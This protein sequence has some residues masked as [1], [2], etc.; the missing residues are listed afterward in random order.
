VYSRCLF[1]AHDLGRNEAI[2]AFPVGRRLAYDAAKGRLWVVCPA[3][4]RWNLT[5]LEERWEATEQAER[6]FRTSR[7]RVS[8]DNVGLARVAGGADLVRVGRPL[9]PELAA[10]RYGDVF[11]RRRRRA[12]A[13]T[14]GVRAA[15]LAGT[16]AIAW[17][18]VSSGLGAVLLLSAG[19]ELIK[20]GAPPET[21]ASDPQG[22]FVVR[23]PVSGVLVSLSRHAVERAR[24]EHTD[25]RGLDL[26]FPFGDAWHRAHGAAAVRGTA[27]LLA[28]LNAA[29]APRALVAGAVS[30]LVAAGDAR[31]FL[32]RVG[33]APTRRRGYG[34]PRAR[35]AVRPTE[36]SH[37]LAALDP[38]DRLALEMALHDDQERAALDGE[39]R[40]L[41]EAWREAESLAAIADGLGLPTRVER[42]LGRLRTG[43]PP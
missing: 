25:A 24:L 17:W 36:W 11:G 8:T 14:A 18:L 31:A 22:D 41:E 2:E 32:A 5:P 27:M 42:A 12:L 7:L 39:M 13:I 28:H 21:A 30:R 1:C 33:A 10:W 40:A 3:C 23:V 20:V 38:V 19:L 6:L 34:S 4:A 9:R 29:G 26:V 16:G 43:R 37:G 15:S 35:T